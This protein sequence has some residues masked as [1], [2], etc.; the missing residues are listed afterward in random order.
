[1]ADRLL[2]AS[3]I[4]RPLPRI[5]F[6]LL[7]GNLDDGN[8]HRGKHGGRNFRQAAEALER[9]GF[10]W[11]RI[12][13][14]FSFRQRPS[15]SAGMG[16]RRQGAASRLSAGRSR[17]PEGSGT[18]AWRKRENGAGTPESQGRQQAAAIPGKPARPGRA[19]SSPS[20]S[21]RRTDFRHAAGAGLRR[22]L[23]RRPVTTSRVPTRNKPAGS[24]RTS[25]PRSSPTW[26]I[27]RT[28]PSAKPAG[29]R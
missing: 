22:E 29:R 17:Q 23:S 10:L 7:L 8:F 24:L 3:R 5:V 11:S 4:P 2:V 18:A 16:P 12:S 25:E 27:V 28:Q 20:P 6:D 21:W 13:W 9:L 1:M 15:F 19:S 14:S 26:G